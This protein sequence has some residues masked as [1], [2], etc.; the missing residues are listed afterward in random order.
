MVGIV[1]LFAIAITAFM[2]HMRPLM[3][4]GQL[5]EAAIYALLLAIGGFLVFI[6]INTLTVPSPLTW[7]LVVYTPILQALGFKIG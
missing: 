3:K 2:L 5:G 7:L 6:T 4:K 1:I